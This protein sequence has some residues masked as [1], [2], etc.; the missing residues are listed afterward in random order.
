MRTVCT[1]TFLHD[2]LERLKQLTA[3]VLANG[4]TWVDCYEHGEEFV[5]AFRGIIGLRERGAGI[6]ASDLLRLELIGFERENPSVLKIMATGTAAAV[7][8]LA[9]CLA[10]CT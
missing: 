8:L 1:S 7:M 10:P 2:G 3:T 9:S 5:G 4:W 6:A